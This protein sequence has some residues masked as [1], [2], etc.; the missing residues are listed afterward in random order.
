MVGRRRREVVV[1]DGV[2]SLLG[3]TTTTPQ[4]VGGSLGQSE[5]TG[6]LTTA[7]Q[8]MLV[9][10]AGARAGVSLL[11]A[12]LLGASVVG[13]SAAVLLHLVVRVDRTRGRG[14]NRDGAKDDGREKRNLHRV[15]GPGVV[16]SLRRTSERSR[17]AQ[18]QPADDL[19]GCSLPVASR[20][21][22]IG[23]MKKNVVDRCLTSR[24]NGVGRGLGES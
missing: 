18:Y 1:H 17:L 8:D 6:R 5:H 14:S 21:R 16:A 11:Q 22:R 12:L 13:A 19:I 20:K 9:L 15:V 7:R 23:R 4:Q 10:N 24:R 3:F 2:A